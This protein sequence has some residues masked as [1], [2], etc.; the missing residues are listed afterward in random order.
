MDVWMALITLLTWSNACNYFQFW[1]HQICKHYQNIT[2]RLVFMIVFGIHCNFFIV[3][4]IQLKICRSNIFFTRQEVVARKIGRVSEVLRARSAT[5]TQNLSSPVNAFVITLSC[6]LGEV[7]ETTLMISRR[8]LGRLQHLRRGSLW[9]L[10]TA[11]N[12][13]LPDPRCQGS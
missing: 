10:L 2:C 12:I 3:S 9:Q 5:G 1:R 7:D 13:R 11:I 8:D 4:P 6:T